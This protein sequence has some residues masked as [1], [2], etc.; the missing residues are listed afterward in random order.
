MSWL[1]RILVGPERS[2]ADWVKAVAWS[3]IVTPPTL[4]FPLVFPLIFEPSLL[5]ER[6]GVYLLWLGLPFSLA[7]VLLL[8]GR[9]LSRAG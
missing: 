3:L 8:Y 6:W 2:K 4:L 9:R 7:A 1:R 5:F